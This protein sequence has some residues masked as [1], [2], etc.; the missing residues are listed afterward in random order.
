MTSDKFVFDQSSLD[1][2][3]ETSTDV[4]PANQVIKR[5]SPSC[6]E[7]RF[8][9]DVS[10]EATI[11]CK[12]SNESTT[13]DA[14]LLEKIEDALEQPEH[15]NCFT[16]LDLARSVI[17]LLWNR[18]SSQNS[19]FYLHLDQLLSLARLSEASLMTLLFYEES[20]E[21]LCPSVIKKFINC[22][23]ATDIRSEY[24][25]ISRDVMTYDYGREMAQIN[26]GDKLQYQ[27]RR[28][29]D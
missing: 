24:R 18:D 22:K 1:S 29:E 26:G 10:S 21:K 16:M 6:F 2:F 20:K 15:A 4:N 19:I 7:T 17:E 14:Y 5:E 8:K 13:S 23:F 3:K 9:Y 11:E 12:G 27:P 28:E 25:E